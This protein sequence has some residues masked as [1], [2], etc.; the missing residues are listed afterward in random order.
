MAK[1]AFVALPRPCESLEKSLRPAPGFA[2][3]LDV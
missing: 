1:L 2:L 3:S